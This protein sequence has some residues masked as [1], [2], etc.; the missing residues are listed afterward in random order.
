MD[1]WVERETGRVR[2]PDQRLKGRLGKLL[3]DLGQ[4]I[5]GTIPAACRIGPR[6][7]RRIG[8]SATLGWT[9]ASSWRP[10]CRDYGPVRGHHWDGA[11]TAR[12]DGSAS[13]ETHP[14]ASGN[15]RSSRAARHPHVWGCSCTPPG[16]HDAA[17][18]GWPQSKFWTRRSSRGQR[19]KRTINP[20]ASTRRRECPLAREPER[21]HAQLG[22]RPVCPRGDGR[23][24][25]YELFC[26]AHE[27]K[28]HFL[29]RTCVDRLAVGEDDGGEAMAREPIRG[30]P[31]GG[32][33][34]RPRASYQ[35]TV[36]RVLS[37]DGSPAGRQRKRY[38]ALSLTVIHA[39]DEEH[40]WVG[41]DPVETTHRPAGGRPRLASEARLYASRWKL[42]PITRC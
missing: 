21:R 35:R 12:H 27:A 8:S 16:A 11:G 14:T 9:K 34:G 17:S 31:R 18:V 25:I 20:L 33:P 39:H 1:V 24:N 13:L 32:G 19:L 2:V 30:S 22:D 28:T 6:P 3:A 36:Y 4:R 40:L 5:G 37:D 41:A 38:P 29:V 23:P 26:A 15:S 10:P 7:R 42:R